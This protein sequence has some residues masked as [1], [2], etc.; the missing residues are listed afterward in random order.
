MKI[1]VISDT[2]IPDRAPML[3]EEFLNKIKGADLI[4][5]AGDLVNLSVIE[6][7]KSI[8]PVKAVWG[9]MDGSKV[10]EQLRQKEIIKLEGVTIGLIH[11]WGNP[12]NLIEVLK[13]EFK[14][15]KIDIIIFGHSHRPVNTKSEN[16]LFFNP[17]SLTDTF[18]SDFASY[19]VIEIN[20]NKYSAKIEKL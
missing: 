10:K 3:P 14:N 5:H 17:G 11:G 16:I 8:A 9:N 7:L 6:Q 19:G 12:N 15:E 4:L 18:F 2:H 20:K 13:N 1:I